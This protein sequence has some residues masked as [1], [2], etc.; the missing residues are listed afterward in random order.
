MVENERRAARYENVRK[1]F[2]FCLADPIYV[3]TMTN[4]HIEYLHLFVFASVLMK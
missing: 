2:V 4:I 3:L 1:K